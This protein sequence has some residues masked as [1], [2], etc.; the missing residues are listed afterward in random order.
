MNGSMG[1]AGHVVYK[2]AAGIKEGSSSMGQTD[3]NVVEV[4]VMVGPVFQA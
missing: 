4:I 2:S 1:M 3:C